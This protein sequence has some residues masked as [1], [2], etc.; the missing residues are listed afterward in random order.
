MPFFFTVFSAFNFVSHLK[1]LLFWVSLDSQLQSNWIMMAITLLSSPLSTPSNDFLCVTQETDVNCFLS[2]LFPLKSILD[3]QPGL[4]HVHK[5][6]VKLISF[7]ILGQFMS[8]RGEHFH[9][10]LFILYINPFL[11]FPFP[12]A[13]TEA[14]SSYQFTL[15]LNLILSCLTM[16]LQFFKGLLTLSMTPKFHLVS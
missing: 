4:Y 2:C 8:K 15:W 7:N 14:H 12:H 9:S 6:G 5:L 13:T 16:I 3:N 10:P 1:F 11:V